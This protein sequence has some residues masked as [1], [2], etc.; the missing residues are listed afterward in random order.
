MARK[1]LQ[2]LKKEYETIDKQIEELELRRKNL[3]DLLKQPYRGEISIEFENKHLSNVSVQTLIEFD[4]ALEE[5]YNLGKDIK[6][7]CKITGICDKIFYVPSRLFHRLDF[8]L[9]TPMKK[10]NM[11]FA[12]ADAIIDADGDLIKNR[13][14]TLENLF[15]K[16]LDVNSEGK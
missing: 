13:Y 15:D 8:P 4:E 10:I 14:G 11:I 1:S 3:N 12:S 16:L 5:S 2:E 7:F 6:K 9:L